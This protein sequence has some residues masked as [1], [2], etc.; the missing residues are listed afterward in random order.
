[1]KTVGQNILAVLAGIVLGSIVNMTI[2]NTGPHVIPLPAGA[3]VTTMEGLRDSMKL[4]TPV[5][6]ICPFLAHALGTLVG[7]AVAA[8]LAASHQRKC[9]ISIGVLFLMG[10]IAMVTMLGGPMWFNAADLLLA[11]I[12]MAL[13]GAALVR[14]TEKTSESTA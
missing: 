12:P 6:F 2:V 10:G 14:R 5:N 9:A 1:M 3:D 8:R 11:Y 7:A 13:L 4:M